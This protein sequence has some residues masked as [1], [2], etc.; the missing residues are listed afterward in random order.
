MW[1]HTATG[2][3]QLLDTA[4]QL[5]RQSETS[6]SCCFGARDDVSL[7]GYVTSR[8][9]TGPWMTALYLDRSLSASVHV[10]GLA[11]GKVCL[12]MTSLQS[13]AR[14]APVLA[15]CHVR[16]RDHPHLSRTRVLTLCQTAGEIWA[17]QLFLEL[18]TLL[19]R[20]HSEMGHK[21][22]KGPRKTAT[23]H[24]T[25][26]SPCPKQQVCLFCCHE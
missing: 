15:S 12:V 21:Q 26:M 5:W 19:W 2:R 14:L 20:H 6:Q 11:P 4:T 10:L 25:I 3:Q 13:N 24:K 1:S 9:A 17:G 7:L 18:S 23:Q 8:D 22:E 16:H